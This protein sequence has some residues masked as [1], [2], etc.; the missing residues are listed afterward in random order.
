[1]TSALRP[2]LNAA[3]GDVSDLAGVLGRISPESILAAADAADR[4]RRSTDQ[5]TNSADGAASANRRF[6]GSLNEIDATAFN[7]IARGAQGAEDEI[8]QL[9]SIQLN[10]LIREAERAANELGTELPQGASNAERALRGLD[11][12]SLD[13]LSLIHI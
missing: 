12:S 2:A 10:D 4:L 8:G 6:A 9:N 5:A 7:R 11:S 3:E 13:D 1:M